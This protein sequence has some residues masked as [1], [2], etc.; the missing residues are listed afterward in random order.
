VQSEKLELDPVIAVAEGA[1]IVLVARLGHEYP[2]VL[3]LE[4][5]LKHEWR[6]KAIDTR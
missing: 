6:G 3:Q 4:E 2:A 1:S 5:A